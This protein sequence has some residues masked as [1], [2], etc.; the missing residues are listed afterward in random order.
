MHLTFAKLLRKDRYLESIQALLLSLPSYRRFP[1]NEEF[2]RELKT[3][4]LYNFPRRSY[5]LRRLENHGRK[6]RVARKSRRIFASDV[7]VWWKGG[8]LGSG[9]TEG[10]L[11]L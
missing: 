10:P 11:E 4:D 5:W 6:E 1:S 7:W 9:R 3:R 2:R 8:G